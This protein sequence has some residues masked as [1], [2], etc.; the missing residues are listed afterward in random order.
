MKRFAAAVLAVSMLAALAACDSAAPAQNTGSETASVTESG[1]VSGSE[2]AADSQSEDGITKEKYQTMTEDDLLATVK[3]INNVTTDEYVELINTLRFVD[4]VDDPESTNYMGLAEN[5][6]TT[7]LGKIEYEA[8]PKFQDYVDTLLQSEYPQVRGYAFSNMGSL[9]GVSDES[10]SKSKEILKTEENDYV[11]YCAISAFSNE[12]KT[13]PDILD[14]AVRMSESDN[15]KLRYRAALA[16]GNSWSIGVDGALDRVLMLMKDENTD[17][18][19]VACQ[20]S[21]KLADDSVVDPLVEII[22]DESE[23]IKVR[24]SCVEGLF[25]LWYDYPFHKNMSEKAYKATMDYFKTTPRNNDIPYW[26]NVGLF[27]NKASTSYDE[28][29]ENA[30]YFDTDELYDVMC[31]I[32]EDSEANWMARTAAVRAIK[33][34]CSEEQFES[35]KTLVDGL[36]DTNARFIQDEYTKQEE[37]E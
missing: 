19:A 25:S 3:D 7:A 2:S 24:K 26:S 10:I 33:A 32:V 31:G 13:D 16:F 22:N 14:F 18:R 20:Y 12:L 11:L 34:Q 4:I 15:P 6:T 17:V 8:K 28:W 27:A 35:L 37:T 21:G 5:I 29:K 1:T 9:F 36:S 23:D 30:T